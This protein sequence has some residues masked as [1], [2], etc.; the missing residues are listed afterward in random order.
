MENRP[1]PA[2]ASG[3]TIIAAVGVVVVAPAVVVTVPGRKFRFQD[4]NRNLE[5]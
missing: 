2:T 5:H 4:M 1:G 3:S